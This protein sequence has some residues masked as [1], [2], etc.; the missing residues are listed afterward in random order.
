MASRWRER[1]NT[2]HRSNGS[3]S[4]SSSPVA[5]ALSPTVSSSSATLPHGAPDDL[6]ARSARRGRITA[7]RRAFGGCRGAVQGGASAPPSQVGAGRRR[8]RPSRLDGQHRS[9]GHRERRW[10]GT[11]S[12][13]PRTRPPRGRHLSL[14]RFRPFAPVATGVLAGAL[15]CASKTTCFAIVYPQPGDALHDWLK[16]RGD[17]DGFHAPPRPFTVRPDLTTWR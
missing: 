7:I 4:C 10:R 15:D 17:H 8:E 11:E 6:G 1:H 12:G 5:R 9:R 3:G 13:D 2:A 14:A 16:F